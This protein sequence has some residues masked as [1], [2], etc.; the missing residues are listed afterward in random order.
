MKGVLPVK[1]MRTARVR[2]HLYLQ[3]V[4]EG[5]DGPAPPAWVLWLVTRLLPSMRRADRACAELLDRETY[6]ATMEAWEREGRAAMARA[7]DALFDAEPHAL[8]DRALLDRIDRA[9]THSARGL[10][11]HAVLGGP[12][13]FAIGKLAFF[14]EDEL[15][16]DPNRVFTLLAGSSPQTTELHRSLSDIADAIARELGDDTTFPATWGALAT[17]APAASAQLAD[18]LERHRLRMTHYEPKHP[19]LGET[20]EVVLS[21]LASIVATRGQPMST[22]ARDRAEAVLDE[23]R[24]KLEPARFAELERLLDVARRAYALRDENGI[25]TVSRPSGLLRWYVLELGRRLGLE[26]PAH[27]VYLEVDEHG[28]ALRGEID[29]LSARIARRR[30]EESW[31]LRHRGPRLLGKAPDMPPVAPF[32]RG[33]RNV[34]RIFAWMMKAETPGR[35][36]EGETLHGVG[37]GERVVRARVRVIDAPEELASLRHGEVLVC[38]ITS[39][40]WSVALA[41]VAAIVTNEGALLSHPAII[42]REYGVTAV[43]GCGPATTHLTTGDRVCVDPIAGTVTRLAR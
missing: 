10:A 11:Q 1:E 34:M 31:A 41:R 12:N 35:G 25:E 43:V 9:L 5:G 29:D 17:R 6:V 2:G 16:W 14:L 23:A 24:A 20:P 22:E 15:G 32:P 37:I 39:P 33:L 28:P 4:T 26:S 40:E 42:A 8:S 13:L 36:V 3:M 38:R 27:A 7:T 19:M 21:V 30:G 18:W